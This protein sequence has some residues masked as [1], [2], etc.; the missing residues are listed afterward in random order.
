LAGNEVKSCFSP[1]LLTNKDGGDRVAA[2]AK[3]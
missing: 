3:Q 2:E 1:S